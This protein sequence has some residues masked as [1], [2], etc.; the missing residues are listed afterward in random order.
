M[1]TNKK[2]KEHVLTFLEK[3]GILGGVSA[4]EE[5]CLTPPTGVEITLLYKTS[6]NNRLVALTAIIKNN[7]IQQNVSEEGF[8]LFFLSQNLKE[9][10]GEALLQGEMNRGAAVGVPD[11]PIT[12][13]LCSS[14]MDCT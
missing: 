13:A 4:I 5:Q 3:W 10:I 14:Q 12:C 9:R 8:V 11:T 2:K 6:L 1:V 7:P